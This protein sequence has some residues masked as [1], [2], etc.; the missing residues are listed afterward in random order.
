MTEERQAEGALVID[1][2]R[3][4]PGYVMGH[5]GPY[6]TSSFA[7]WPADAS[8]MPTLLASAPLPRT[9]AFRRCASAPAQ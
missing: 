6:V 8:G 9:S 4:K 3:N 5:E 7:P 1:T 2:Q